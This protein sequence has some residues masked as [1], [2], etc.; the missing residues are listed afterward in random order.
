MRQALDLRRLRYFL[1]IAEHGSISA[2]ARSLNLAQPAL[3]Y[4]AGELER[5]LG[6]KMFER[7]RDGVL[8]TDAGRLLRR[9]AEEIVARVHAAEAA[10][11][12]MATSRGPEIRVSVAIIS[13]LAADLT[14]LLV[15]AVGRE[16]PEVTLRIIEAGTRDIEHRLERADADLAVYLAGAHGRQDLPL[17]TEQLFF[18]APAPAVASAAPVALAEV[19]RHRLVLPSPDNPLRRFID[20]VARQNGLVLDIA[21]EID[22][23]RSRRNAVRS[24]IGCTILGAHAVVGEGDNAGLSVRE[25]VS[26]RLFRPIFIGL[27]RDLDPA[28][29][30]RMTAIL[31][32]A[33]LQMGLSEPQGS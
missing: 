33:L 18:L 9:H 5:L 20:T 29:G 23:S 22:G 26:P 25:I 16:M 15:A 31:R 32:A 3:S 13:S 8:L 24:G 14:P 7:S 11:Q 1:A 30:G 28:L 12:S 6:L 2:A 4:H 19:A 27:R 21:L 10:M 17:A